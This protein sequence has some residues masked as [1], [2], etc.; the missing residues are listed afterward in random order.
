[1]TDEDR[2]V[3]DGDTAGDSS[4]ATALAEQEFL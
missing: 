2:N 1:M 3:V 4:K